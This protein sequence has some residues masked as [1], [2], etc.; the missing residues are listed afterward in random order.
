MLNGVDYNKLINEQLINPVNYINTPFNLQYD[1]YNFNNKYVKQN[2]IVN[3]TPFDSNVQLINNTAYL[4]NLEQ[5]ANN[6]F[7]GL[8]NIKLNNFNCNKIKSLKPKLNNSKKYILK[9]KNWNVQKM[10]EKCNYFF[11]KK[12]INNRINPKDFNNDDYSK[13]KD[14]LKIG[15]NYVD[16]I[17]KNKRFH[18][19]ME[20]VNNFKYDQ[21][22]FYYTFVNDQI[23]CF[24]DPYKDNLLP[25]SKQYLKPYQPLNIY[26]KKSKVENWLKTFN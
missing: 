18:Y 2:E 26:E 25:L 12:D 1:Y 14:E 20:K 11:Y 19:Y 21:K 23:F 7:P 17:T 5:N 22:G 9:K 4:T 13:L 24:T 15:T 8:S 16:K 10:V 6:F 3:N